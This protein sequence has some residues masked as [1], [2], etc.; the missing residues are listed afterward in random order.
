MTD[1]WEN[2]PDPRP[3]LGVVHWHMLVG[4][5]S[6]VSATAIAAQHL[7]AGFP[8]LHMTPLRWLHITLLVAGT[9]DDIDRDAMHVMLRHAGELVSHIPP[10][11]VEI[12]RVIYHPEAVML[13][14]TP[15]Y[16]L[17]PVLDAAQSATRRVTGKE[18][19]INGGSPSDWTPHITLCYST[20]RQPAGP[21]IT[22]VGK[23]LG[24]WDITVD[25]LSLV[26]QWGSERLWDW[27]P[28]GTI[29]LTGND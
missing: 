17:R 27:E 8:E 24:T 14:V 4:G 10:A 7:L 16:I 13:A 23:S 5:N 11:R 1:R 3:G 25:S 20:A 6:T 18:G 9:T 2:R 26:V 12:G 29:N 15:H 22:A 19:S 28:V 21:V